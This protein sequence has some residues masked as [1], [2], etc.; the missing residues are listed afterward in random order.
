MYVNKELDTYNETI[1]KLDNL[2]FTIPHN[3]QLSEAQQESYKDWIENIE[4]DIDLNESAAI[5]NDLISEISS[6]TARNSE[7]MSVI[8]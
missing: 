2:S 7:D 6:L 1:K 5:L 8:E 3:K 4:K